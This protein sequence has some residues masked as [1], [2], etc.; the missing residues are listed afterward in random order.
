MLEN[1]VH[2]ARA[3]R[4][5]FQA[6]LWPNTSGQRDAGAESPDTRNCWQSRAGFN[7]G[8]Q[9][10]GLWGWV[11]VEPECADAQCPMTKDPP[12]PACRQ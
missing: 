1:D 7:A 3:S 4:R 9:E 5:A 8:M 12:Y 2:G 11:L 6:L 10:C